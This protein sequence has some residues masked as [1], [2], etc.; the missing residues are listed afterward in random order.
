[1][2]ILLDIDGV[3]CPAIPW[4]P[5]ELLDD[6]FVRFTDLS[7]ILLNKII[8]ETDASVIL[9]TSYKSKYS[10]SEW[11]NIFA[12]RC[13][14][15]KIGKLDDNISNLSRKDEILNW[16]YNNNIDD[17]VIID[18]DKSLNGLPIYLKSKLVSTNSFTGMKE[19]DAELAIDILKG[20]I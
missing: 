19:C 11:E 2:L 16:V 10:I 3:M 18:D 1:M 20:C 7:I 14:Y 17:F 4:K 15:V 8:S 5:A 13:I 6:G 12:E 9:T